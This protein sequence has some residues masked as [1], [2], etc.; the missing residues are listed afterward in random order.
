MSFINVSKV[1]YIWVYFVITNIHPSHSLKKR[2]S[3]YFKGIFLPQKRGKHHAEV[4][5]TTFFYGVFPVGT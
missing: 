5:K 4:G 2:K 3:S 1:W